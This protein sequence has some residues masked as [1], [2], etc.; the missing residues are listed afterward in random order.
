MRLNVTIAA[1]L[2]L[3]AGCA[4]APYVFPDR[5]LVDRDVVADAVATQKQ[6]DAQG[7]KDPPQGASWFAVIEGPSPVI[8][9]A[10]HAAMTFRERTARF[11]DGGGT[12]ALAKALNR[13]AGATVLYTTYAG[14]SDP[15]YYDDNEFKRTLDKLIDERKPVL[16]L[17][18]HGS[19]AYCP[20]DVDMGTMFGK[21][22]MGNEAAAA[23]LA[24]TLKKEGILNISY[25]FSS[26][27]D[28][29][30]IAKFA[31][32]RNVPAIQLEINRTWLT[33]A[34]SDLAAHRFAQLLQAL[35]RYIEAEK[36]EAPAMLL[37]EA[38]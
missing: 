4:P 6:I 17:D 29:D 15:D 14:P 3:L 12:A 36:S 27:G 23:R 11:S 34:Q 25:N 16:V 32:Q 33:P 19:H 24:E 18:I 13:V 28:R 20:Y 35:A 9:T 1:V 30:T 31:S 5:A 2:L 37:E 10:P 26:A 38:R 21:S 22:L 7:E 8:V